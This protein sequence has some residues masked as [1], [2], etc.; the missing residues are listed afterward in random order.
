[1]QR[2]GCARPNAIRFRIPEARHREGNILLDGH[3]R[4]VA[5]DLELRDLTRSGHGMNDEAFKLSRGTSGGRGHWTQWQIQPSANPRPDLDPDPDPGA[6]A[7]L[8]SAEVQ[9]VKASERQDGPSVVDPQP[10]R[11]DKRLQ[12]RIYPS[13]R[14]TR[15]SRWMR[16]S[17]MGQASTH[18][19]QDWRPDRPHDFAFGSVL[20][21]WASAPSSL[22]LLNS[23]R[24]R[25][26]SASLRVHS[27]PQAATWTA[28][29]PVIA[30]TE[31]LT[32]LSFPRCG[33]DVRW[34]RGVTDAD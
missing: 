7:E 8:R 22:E 20:R 19:C 10:V 26:T 15:T 30:T 13:A 29:L 21:S 4:A 33:V 17:G 23:G 11:A 32:A 3:P 31:R 16:R 24:G 6:G 2:H 27:D 12:L 25:R 14:D 34:P 28:A 9:P 5:S 18:I 1:M